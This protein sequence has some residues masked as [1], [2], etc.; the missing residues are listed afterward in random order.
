MDNLNSS[1]VMR[2]AD[3][4]SENPDANPVM[5]GVGALEGGAGNWVTGLLQSGN[6]LLGNKKCV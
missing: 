1:L 2:M 3:A 5:S 4:I 6:D